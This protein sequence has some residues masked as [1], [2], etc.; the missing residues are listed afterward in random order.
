MAAVCGVLREQHG[1]KH[2]GLCTTCIMLTT[3][4]RGF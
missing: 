3:T 2:V 1:V 4:L